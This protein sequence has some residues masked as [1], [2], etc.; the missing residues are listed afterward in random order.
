M[1]G[2]VAAAW[3]VSAGFLA[4]AFLVI[5]HHLIASV[6]DRFEPPTPPPWTRAPG[7]EIHDGDA[8][9]VQIIAG[10]GADIQYEEVPIDPDLKD[11]FT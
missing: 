1:G 4:I 2:A 11:L 10:P 9:I 8:Y 3:W 6:Q 7:T 5:V